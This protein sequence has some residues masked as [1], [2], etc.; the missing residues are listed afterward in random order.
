[1]E[2]RDD[3]RRRDAASAEIARPPVDR[4]SQVASA[5]PG[6]LAWQTRPVALVL[7]LRTPPAVIR[8]LSNNHFGS[9]VIRSAVRLLSHQKRSPDVF[10]KIEIA[11]D[12]LPVSGDPGQLQQAIIALATNALDAMGD[13]GVLTILGRNEDEK[14]VVEVSGIPPGT[15][16]PYHAV[17]HL[18]FRTM[19]ELAGAL[20]DTAAEFIADEKKYA[21]AGSVVQISEVVE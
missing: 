2:S 20:A 13:S 4:A 16:P 6:R 14:V 3:R 11:P 18:F 9:D 17:G 19:A 21:D 1:M 8:R 5:F 7:T 12:L 15:P 10:F